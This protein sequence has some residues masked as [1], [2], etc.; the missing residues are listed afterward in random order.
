[1]L[2]HQLGAPVT[3]NDINRLS[4]WYC[5]ALYIKNRQDPFM[6]FDPKSYKQQLNQAFKEAENIANC[7]S[8]ARTVDNSPTN[9]T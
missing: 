5:H 6:D 3:Q 2:A 9:N 8:Q 7:I 1:M 4:R